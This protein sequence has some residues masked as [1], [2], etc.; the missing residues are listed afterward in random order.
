[1]LFF[2]TLRA[3]NRRALVS[4]HP[5]LSTR[6]TPH[7]RLRPNGCIGLLALL[8]SS[9]HLCLPSLYSISSS[10]KWHNEIGTLAGQPHRDAVRTYWDNMYEWASETEAH[11]NSSAQFTKVTKSHFPRL[12][13]LQQWSTFY[14]LSTWYMPGT[15]LRNYIP[16]P[17]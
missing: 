17:G 13:L 15:A 1:M 6:P 9:R 14:L 3:C 12:L 11:S 16:Q 2:L 7:F 8:P 10:L 4:L 5:F